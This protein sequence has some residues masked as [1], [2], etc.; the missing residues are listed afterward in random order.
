MTVCKGGSCRF[1]SVQAAVDSAPVNRTERFV[2]YIREG[3]YNETVR[4]PF[5]KPNLAFV[6]DGMGK[7]VLTGSLNADMVG[8]ST[9]NTA[10][11]GEFSHVHNFIIFYSFLFR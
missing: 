3:V 10:T 5:E 11:V 9:Y 2:I 8:V 6:G 4:V 7:T 1:D